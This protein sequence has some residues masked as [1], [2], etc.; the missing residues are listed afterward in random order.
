MKGT[1][2]FLISL[3]LILSTFLQPMASPIPSD[4]PGTMAPPEPVTG[5]IVIGDDW[6]ITTYARFL[7]ATIYL[8]GNLTVE[9][10]GHLEFTNTTLA[11]NLTG[12]GQFKIVI[13]GKLTLVDY[14][15]D[16][17]TQGDAS[18]IMSNNS[19]NRYTL[20]AQAGSQISF[21][22]SIIRNCGYSGLNQGV[23]VSTSMAT[24]D[25]MLFENNHY[26]LTIKSNAVSV[27]NCTFTGHY[28][29]I[30]S[31]FCNP[32][33]RNLTITGSTARGIFLYYS[34]PIIEDCF[35][36]NN[37]IGIYFQNS[38]PTVYSCMINGSQVAGIQTWYSSPLLV[39]CALSNL[40]DMD[41]VQNSFPRLLNTTLDESKVRASR[42]LY[43]SVGQRMGVSVVN[44]TGSPMPNMK[45]SVLDSE[46][47]P[48]SSGVTN[49]TGIAP[50]L[51]FRQKFLTDD[52]P[53]EMDT[54]RVMAFSLVGE[55]VTYGEN[56]T[57]LAADSRCNV[58]VSSNPIG[59]EIW[60]AGTILTDVRNYTDTKIISLGDLTVSAGTLE[61]MNSTLFF[62]SQSTRTFSMA[63]GN[64]WLND[65]GISSIGTT[66]LLEPAR[67]LVTADTGSP[68]H[69]IDSSMR[70]ITEFIIR[71]SLSDINGLDIAHASAYGLKILSCSPSVDNV[72]IDWAPIG[73]QLSGDTAILSNIVLG[74]ARTTGISASQSAATFRGMYINNSATGLY[75]YNCMLDVTDARIDGCDN[76]IYGIN[77]FLDG[78]NLTVKNSTNAAIIAID[79]S[80]IVSAIEVANSVTGLQLQ[81]S[82]FLGESVTL[83][84]NS[85]G[86][87]VLDC[88]PVLLNSSFNNPLNVKVGR[89]SSASLVNC[90]IDLLRTAIQ[91]SGFIDIGGWFH[92]RVLDDL[93]QPVPG[94]HVSV[95]DS[96]ERVSGS[97]IT[98]DEGV[99]HNAA[100]RQQ[101]LFW[102]GTEEYNSHR[103]L[104]FD[105]DLQDS[106]ITS[107]S[108]NETIDVQVS[109]LGMGWVEWT[110]PTLIDY[111]A[112]Y[113]DTSII[114][115]G[116]LTIDY[117]NLDLENTTLWFLG[118]PG[119]NTFMEVKNG[120]FNMLDSKLMMLGTRAPL[121]PNVLWVTYR[122]TAYGELV[123]SLISGI[124]QITT[125]TG[126]LV[127]DGC[128]LAE[129]SGDGLYLQ[130]CAPTVNNTLFY[131]CINGIW[132]NAGAPVV[133]HSRFI[134]CKDNGFYANGGQI[135]VNDSVSILNNFGFYLANCIGGSISGCLAENNVHGFY[136]NAASPEFISTSALNNTNSGFYLQDSHPNLDSVI[137]A[138]NIY[139][140]FMYSSWPVILNSSFNANYYGI[141]A[142]QSAPFLLACVLDEN[143]VG[144]YSVD[145][146][147]GMTA[148]AFSSGKTEES[149]VFLDGGLRD[150]ISVTL[151]SRAIVREVNIS[152]RGSELESDSVIED[153]FTQFSPEIHGNL[154]VWQDYRNG[155]WNI[156]AYDL[157]MD[158]D[159]NGVPNYLETPSLVNDPALVRVASSPYS[160]VDPD[161]YEDTI[162]W[163]DYRNGNPDI[164][165]YCFTNSTEWAVCTNPS[166]QLKPAIDGDI[167]VWQDLRSGNYDI[168]MVNITDGKEERISDSPDHD[169]GVNI[170]G[171]TVVW[172]SYYGSP[173]S[174]Y[175]DIIMYD[176]KARK[177][178]NINNDAAIQYCPD[179][180]D[181]RVVWHDNRNGNW[182]IYQYNIAST[183]ISRLTYDPDGQQNFMP[184]IYEDTVVYYFHNQ[185]T[186]LWSARM[187]NITTGVQT[188]LERDLDGDSHPVIHGQKIAWV[189]RTDI[190]NDIYV[191]DLA[192]SGYPEDVSIDINKDGIDEFQH[193]G[194]FNGVEY[195]T[196]SWLADVFNQGLDRISGGTTTI[197]FSIAANGTGR[198]VLSVLELVCDIPTYLVATTISNS[199]TTGTQCTDSSPVF[200][201]SSFLDNPMDFSMGSE[202]RPRT[203]NT[204]FSD[205]KLDFQ[206]Y[207][208]N[209]TVQN[210]LH[211]RVENL[212]GDPLDARVLVRDNGQTVHDISTGT[213]GQVMWMPVTDRT[214]NYTGRYGNITIVTVSMDTNIFPD[215]PRNV[216]MSSGHWEIFSTDSDGPR[217]AD[218]F[219]PPGWTC[220]VLRPEISIKITDNLG[221]NISTVRLYVQS[222]AVFYEYAPVPGGYNISY[223][224][225]VDFADGS[226]VNCRLYGR[227]FHGN[228]VDF[229][230]VFIIDAA[231][232]YFSTDL[233]AGWNL[234][235]IPFDTY[236]QSIENVLW[237]ISGKYDAVKTY[238]RLGQG[239]LWLLYR[240]GGSEEL[241][242]ITTIDSKTGYWIHATEPCTLKVS[243]VPAESTGITLLAGWNLVGYPSL[244]EE[245]VAY[246]LWGTG[247]DRMDVF[248]AESPYI[249]EVGST[250][251]MKP[252]EGYWVHVP[253]DSVWTVEW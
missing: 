49:S 101:R 173:G 162:I 182:E 29:A 40:L 56:I 190:K 169:M 244:A 107:V 206:D 172:Y 27:R 251:V 139:G 72:T 110:A 99:L 31:Y 79:S 7:N 231:A 174:D 60:P 130:N 147:V 121:Q 118:T 159:G 205:A 122:S 19:F 106:S 143:N 240:P 67:V 59:V 124:T 135:L 61:L 214:H 108:P 158:S 225:P 5:T 92:V 11:M 90:T 25:G 138:G 62:S 47:N 252:G 197:P 234:V 245:S 249:V 66:R 156:Y 120:A 50:N 175:S 189:N 13:L 145:D 51:V 178:L 209:L 126:N 33:L 223:Q 70:W 63:A 98:D 131:R 105:G 179:V 146:A 37:K 14:D 24:F 103:I 54:H 246:A 6:N 199:G 2:A 93:L 207:L 112:D 74:R 34:T 134:E 153:E 38:E 53:I 88:S 219:P 91:P 28:Y 32:T 148:A 198:V 248:V 155:L 36:Q 228:A 168:Y 22:N 78:S 48:A 236:D 43:A 115:H 183:A 96:S 89:G 84:N 250:Y 253:T 114:V 100:F 44:E 128:V 142:Y 65:S 104:A 220:N 64:L 201:N 149:A 8:T 237:S 68:V 215:N 123:R 152:A 97:G 127:I 132:S 166:A 193:P 55:N 160:Q 233:H 241:N 141:Y 232:V 125:Y 154:V 216:N 69:F 243:G 192:L 222:F 85:V 170:Q 52:G 235:S 239:G 200:V 176:I 217:T 144:F 187:F 129:M 39:D 136:L 94:C 109:P 194:A 18:C 119:A 177:S 71:N 75:S 161:V 165:A 184:R 208:S 9:L 185:L 227:D 116:G 113:Q 196:G 20:I 41:I 210:Y 80:F 81:A 238:S 188:I 12:N 95:L 10:I 117:G 224:H 17:G 181:D 4:T 221:V 229:S 30:Y 1:L 133:S 102:N 213:D 226:T 58:E 204:T 3:F 46:G 218:P 111:Y 45:V 15:F 202:S 230:W 77:T 35:L 157:K 137:S 191:L 151:P 195:I 23:V 82:E 164:Y 76:G 203:L 42:G 73:L 212:T 26:G 180:Y 163:V 83:N 21:S 87:D 247:A 211:V 150:H 16:P 242:S 167:I 186:N 171:N 86:M 57:L 140:A